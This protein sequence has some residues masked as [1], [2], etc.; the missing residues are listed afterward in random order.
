[1]NAILVDSSVWIDYYRPQK[2]SFAKETLERLFTRNAPLRLCPVIYQEVLQGV[3]DHEFRAIKERLLS[4]PMVE[5]D[6]LTATDCAIDIYRQLRRKGKTVRNAADC[7]I[8]AYALCGE[9]WLLHN[10][11]DFDPIAEEFPLKVW[12][13]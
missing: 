3:K 5:T 1:M 9:R 10:D 6:L 7:L 11:R 2:K 8:A 12:R 13:P 4:Y